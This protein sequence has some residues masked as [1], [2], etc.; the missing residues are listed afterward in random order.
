MAGDLAWFSKHFE[1]HNPV[2]CIVAT[3]ID[4]TAERKVSSAELSEFAARC[5]FHYFEVCP[6]TGL[7]I[8]PLFSTLAQD[9]YYRCITKIAL[10]PIT[11][12]NLDFRDDR[13]FFSFY[14]LPNRI[15]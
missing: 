1:A 4:L 2:I 8:E 13:P 6:Q 15:F 7:N 3:K 11:G 9:V 10:R 12:T 14:L 5:G